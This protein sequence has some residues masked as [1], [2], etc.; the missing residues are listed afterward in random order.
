MK[1]ENFDKY[2]FEL[3]DGCEKV[4]IAKDGKYHTIIVD[5]KKVGIVGF[6]PAKYSKNTGFI[7][8]IIIPK[9]R[10]KGLVKQAENLLAKKYKLKRLYATIRKDNIASICVH[11]KIGFKMLSKEKLNFLREKNFLGKN[12]I[13]LVKRY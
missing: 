2:F 5:D 9:F 4:S 11:Q 12:E 6:I 7:Q 10:G 8:I 3:I 13:R 1:L